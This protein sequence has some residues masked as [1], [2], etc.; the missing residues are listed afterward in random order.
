[1]KHIHFVGIGG[2]G[3]SAIA[4]ICLARGDSVTGSD[5]RPNRLTDGLCA[6]GAVVYKGHEGRNVPDSTDILVKSACI[7][8]DNPEIR[9][10]GAL[11][12]D[13]ITRSEMLREIVEGASFSMAIAGTHGKT[14]TSALAAHIAES[15]G[16]NPTVLIGGETANFGGNAKLGE[17]GM[18]IAEIDESDGYFRNISVTCAI[19]TNVEREHME[20]YGSFE[21]LACAY[22]EFISR[23]SKRGFLVFNGEDT[24]LGEL[25][26][27]VGLEK[28]SFG[29]EGDFDVT[30]RNYEH[31]RSI[32][33]DL[34][35]NGRNCGRVS[36]C[37]PGR[38]NL[39]NI[40]GAAAMCIK[41]GCNPEGIIDAIGSFRGVKRRFELCGCAEGVNVIQDYAHHPTELSAVIRAARHYSAGRIITVFQPH[42]YSRTRD[43]ATEFSRCFYDTD[44]LILTDIYSA[45]E[46]DMAGGGIEQIYNKIEKDR[47]ERID[48]VEKKN[49]PEFITSIAKAGDTVLVLGAGDIGEIP[50]DI[51]EKI[52][53]KETRYKEQ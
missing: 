14:T 2:I 50:E 41:V 40:L 43:L 51:I 9:R 30:C 16:K 31:A 23:I 48:L 12:I 38:Y 49:I 22:G 36:S 45:D 8:A 37:L 24:V 15:C 7:V 39:M 19:I 20:H 10:A 11:G 5:L 1:M 4:D 29:I 52:R 33:F 6:R 35:V 46:T 25:T 53:A 18:V 44:I 13:V 47:F 28:I 26:V 21:N 3:M 17:S 32:S 34:I 27:K 42:R